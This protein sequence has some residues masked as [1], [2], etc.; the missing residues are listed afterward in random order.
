[1]QTTA[2]AAAAASA[3]II[4]TPI[5]WFEAAEEAAEKATRRP[6]LPPREPPG[7]PGRALPLARV[8]RIVG[9]VRADDRRGAVPGVDRHRDWQRHGGVLKGRVA[10]DGNRDRRGII[11]AIVQEGR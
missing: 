2:I 8:E 6:G 1:M 10:R 11:A 3:A 5:V 9:R 4:P 7:P